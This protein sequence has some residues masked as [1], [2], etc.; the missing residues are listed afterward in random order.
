[1]LRGGQF[2]FGACIVQVPDAQVAIRRTR[3]DA[4]SVREEGDAGDLL[5]VACKVQHLLA[6]GGLKKAN[7]H[8]S[9]RGQKPAVGRKTQRISRGFV[10]LPSR[11]QVEHLR[12]HLADCAGREEFFICADEV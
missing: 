5:F 10:D 9:S 11:F 7:A 6:R 3:Y 8:S 2:Q 4:S 1:V 12:G